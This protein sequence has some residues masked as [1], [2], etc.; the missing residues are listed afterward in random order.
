MD[1]VI[2]FPNALIGE[3]PAL[4]ACTKCIDPV[5]RTGDRVQQPGK[6]LGRSPW[7][8][9]PQARHWHQHIE[10]EETEGHVCQDFSVRPTGVET[11]LMHIFFGQRI[12]QGMESCARYVKL[13][14]YGLSDV[15]ILDN[16]I[17]SPQPAT[18]NTGYSAQSFLVTLIEQSLHL[19]T[20]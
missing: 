15:H 10:N 11:L 18:K 13:R 12:Q 14:S 5:E 17:P 3:D 6:W 16:T 2:Y 4:S 19:G 8:S 7:Q 9:S 1:A 20:D